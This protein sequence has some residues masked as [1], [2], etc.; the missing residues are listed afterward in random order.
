[1]EPLPEDLSKLSAPELQA[2]LKNR[3]E[4]IE[5]INNR[6]P[7]YWE[8]HAKEL[9]D[10]L[11]TRWSVGSG[12]IGRIKELGSSALRVVSPLGRVRHL[13]GYLHFENAVRA[14]MD[15]RGPNSIIQ[16]YASDIG[17]D[18]GRIFQTLIWSICASNGI[19]FNTF[20]CNAVHDSLE[21][22]THWVDAPLTLYFLEHA[23][24]TQ[25]HKML[26]ETFDAPLLVDLD[27]DMEFGGSLGHMQKWDG[28][29]DSLAAIMQEEFEWMNETF[30]WNVE[31]SDV[32]KAIEHNCAILHRIKTSEIN[33]D[34]RDDKAFE[35]AGKSY[36]SERMLINRENIKKTGLIFGF[37]FENG[38]RV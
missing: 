34:I 10:K 15:R 5:E 26:R 6:D 32:V 29:F 23:M 24:T 16:G 2:L 22:E 27:N 1:M 25:A 28:R 4:K 36:V 11:F 9:I 20:Q 12:W 38:K 31:V 17:F 14:A 30:E 37:E 18:A 35:K 33:L 13:F 19:P 8:N 3:R 21:T 7:D